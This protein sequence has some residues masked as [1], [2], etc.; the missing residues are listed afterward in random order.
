[1]EIRWEVNDGYI[2]KSRPQRTNISNKKIKECETKQEAIELIEE[3]ITTDF[4]S[5]GWGYSNYEEV[6]EQVDSL[7][8]KED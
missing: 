1:M 3:C 6:L 8:N 2:G 4:E 5:L 7:L